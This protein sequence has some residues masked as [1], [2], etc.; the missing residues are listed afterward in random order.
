[1]ATPQSHR[2]FF[3]HFF[4]VVFD[5]D[6]S[7]Y[8]TVCQTSFFKRY[9]R[10]GH[11]WPYHGLTDW[12]YGMV[13]DI[14]DQKSDKKNVVCETVVW[15]LTLKKAGLG[16]RGMVTARLGQKPERQRPSSIKT[17]PY[18]WAT[19]AVVRIGA[20]Q[21]AVNTMVRTRRERIQGFFLDV[22]VRCTPTSRRKKTKFTP[23]CS[24]PSYLRR[25][26]RQQFAGVRRL[27][28]RG[29]FDGWQTPAVMFLTQSAID[30]VKNLNAGVRCPSKLPL[31]DRRRKS[32]LKLLPSRSPHTMARNERGW[33]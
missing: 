1:M 33:I 21:I 18:W 5:Q 4:K 25:S 7:G 19:D 8:T 26:G 28:V 11:Q 24:A 29:S 15:L 2:P 30:L 12:V 3:F 22:D 27:S 17:S 20:L 32:A 6:V 13:T 14:L 10:L 31:I 9:F 23:F 16:D